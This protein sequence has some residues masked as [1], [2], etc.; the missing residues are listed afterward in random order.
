M[1]HKPVSVDF[2]TTAPSVPF[3]ILRHPP[4]DGSSSTFTTESSSSFSLGFSMGAS[5]GFEQ[6]TM[7]SAGVSTTTMV[8]PMGIGTAFDVEAEASVTNTS[9]ISGSVTS[10]HETTWEYTSS[11][12]FSTAGSDIFVGGA[13]NILYGTTDILSL[14]EDENKVWDYSVK[15]DILFLPKGFATT[16]QYSRTYIENT[17]LPELKSLS[18]VDSTKLKDID[19]WNEILVYADN[20]AK[21]A[22]FVEN[23]SFDGGAGSFT[24]STSSSSTSFKP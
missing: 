8:A 22:S 18:V 17:L 4:G 1:G 9:S 16:F 20:L 23:R 6:E 15:R 24:S 10:A 5:A 3:L 19:L 13:M 21:D 14:K 11:E 2:T 7:V 12:S